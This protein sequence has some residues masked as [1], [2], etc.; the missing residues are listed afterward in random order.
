MIHGFRQGRDRISQPAAAGIQPLHKA[1]RRRIRELQTKGSNTVPGLRNVPGIPDYSGQNFPPGHHQHGPGFDA[2]HL[3]IAVQTDIPAALQLILTENMMGGKEFYILLRRHARQGIDRGIQA[4]QATALRFLQPL[5][6]VVVAVKDDP[7]V[8]PDVPDNQVMKDVPETVLIR[9][10]RLQLIGKLAQ[11]LRDDGI[12]NHI[13]RGNGSGGAEGTELELVAGKGKGRRPVPVRRI[14]RELRQHVD[15]NGHIRLL[16]AAVV[17]AAFQGFED[18][19]QLI[20]QKNRDHSRRG[21]KSAKSKI[22]A[23]AG[24]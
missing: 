5:S 14:L 23:G 12:Q 7:L 18:L 21:F 22:I 15:P 4:D 10:C 2:N 24:H 20:A 17:R 6:G 11:A 13:G 3:R 8:L 19:G 9:P 1:F 16:P